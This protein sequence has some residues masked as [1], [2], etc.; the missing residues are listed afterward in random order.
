VQP[1]LDEGIVGVHWLTREQLDNAGHRLRSPMVLRC[2]DDLCSG[3][4]FPL[5]CLRYIETDPLAAA[6][7]A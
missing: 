1:T 4:R 7:L 3:A 5:D 6:K 2:I